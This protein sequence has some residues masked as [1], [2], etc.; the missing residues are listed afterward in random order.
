MT[1]MFELGQTKKKSN[2]NKSLYARIAAHCSKHNLVRVDA[3]GQYRTR[4]FVKG[5]PPPRPSVQ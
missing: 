5:H 2:L 1:F 4:E 3:L